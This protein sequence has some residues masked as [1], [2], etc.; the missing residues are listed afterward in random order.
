M[1]RVARKRRCISSTSIGDIS[2][3][4][5]GSVWNIRSV[6]AVDDD[7]LL[8]SLSLAADETMILL[9]FDNDNNNN[10]VMKRSCCFIGC[11]FMWSLLYIFIYYIVLVS[12]L[13]AAVLNCSEFSNGV[14]GTQQRSLFVHVHCSKVHSVFIG[15]ESFHKVK[16]KK[17][18]HNEK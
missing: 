11:F 6:S 9:F 5:L 18:L 10:A 7:W 16:T 8:P 13:L 3:G 4:S 1:A 15:S 2:V 14:Q 12:M 17:E